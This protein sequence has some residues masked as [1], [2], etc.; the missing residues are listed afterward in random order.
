MLPFRIKICGL[1]DPANVRPTVEAG[2][3]ALGLNFYPQSKR[4]LNP[5]QAVT[6]GAQIPDGITRVGVFVDDLPP[7]IFM[8]HYLFGYPVLNYLQLHGDESVDQLKHLTKTIAQFNTGLISKHTRP[9]LIKA[10]RLKSDPETEIGSYLDECRKRKVELAGILIDAFSTVGHG[11]TG[12]RADWAALGRWTDRRG[13]PLILAGGIT[14]E[15]VAEAIA[16]VRPDAIDTASGVESS[17]GIK[18]P[19]KVRR[20]VA[21]ATAAWKSIE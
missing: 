7:L 16:T 15:N 12:E 5:E 18:D 17:P 19:D 10:F 1:T 4:Y 20:L 14:P 3:Q 21:A 8:R 11:G 13:V 2:A 9:R 6:I